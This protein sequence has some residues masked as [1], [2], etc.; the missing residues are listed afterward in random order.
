MNIKEQKRILLKYFYNY[1]TKVL[2]LSFLLGIVTF[3]INPLIFFLIPPLT[4][5]LLLG[6]VVRELIKS[7]PKNRKRIWKKM[8]IFIG[9]SVLLAALAL[10]VLSGIVDSMFSFM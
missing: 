5:V 6:G 2:A 10:F 4:I 9:I 1:Y 8:I 7:T 3:L